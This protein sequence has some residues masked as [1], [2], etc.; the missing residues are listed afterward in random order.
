MWQKIVIVWSIFHS[1]NWG[2]EVRKGYVLFTDSKCNW[3][4]LFFNSLVIK[5]MRLFV[6]NL[7]MFYDIEIIGNLFVLGA[8]ICLTCFVCIEDFPEEQIILKEKY[9]S[10]K[11]VNQKKFET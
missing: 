10:Y 8:T 7:N 1:C 9:S 2:W 11:K 6:S 3:H 4:R 5:V